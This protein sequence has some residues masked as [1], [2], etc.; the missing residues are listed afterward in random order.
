MPH[1]CEDEVAD[2]KISAVDQGDVHWLACA[3]RRDLDQRVVRFFVD[4]GRREPG[5]RDLAGG[6]RARVCGELSVRH[7]RSDGSN[8]GAALD[9][10]VVRP[11]CQARVEIAIV[12]A[13]WPAVLFVRWEEQKFDLARIRWKEERGVPFHKLA[14]NIDH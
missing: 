13:S 12:R 10:G 11:W 8:E 9:V 1:V 14:V 6:W 5:G 4:M 7:Q 3:L 2:P